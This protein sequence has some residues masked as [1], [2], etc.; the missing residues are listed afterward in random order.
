MD[1][2]GNFTLQS[3]IGLGKAVVLGQLSVVENGGCLRTVRTE[4]S[5]YNR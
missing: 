5:I 3:A 2:Q 4:H 1:E